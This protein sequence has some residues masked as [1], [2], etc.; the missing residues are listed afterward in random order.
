VRRLGVTRT[1]GHPPGPGVLLRRALLAVLLLL[2]AGLAHPYPAG[3]RRERAPLAGAVPSKAASVPL[4]FY[5]G[6][7]DTSGITQAARTTGTHPALAEDF[8]VGSSGW[9][10]MVGQSENQWLLGAWANKGYQ[11]V[12]GV[13]IIP[14][15]NG[16]AVGTLAQ[17]ATG[18]YDGYF[19]TLAHTLVSYGDANAILRLGWEFNGNWYTWAVDNG[20]EAA[21]YAAYFDHIVTAMRA[22][23]PQFKFVWNTSDATGSAADIDAAY[24]GDAYV[25]YI[26]V[27]AYDEYCGSNP[28]S[29]GE[30]NNLLNGVGGLNWAASF[31]AA[32]GKSVAVPEWGL[33][34]GDNSGCIGLG[35][36]PN[37]VNQMASWL[38]ANHAAF[39]S[40]FDFDASDA[41]HSLEDGTFPNAVAAFHQDFN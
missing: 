1:P 33:A 17:G 19:T 16:S 9:S 35:D 8:L 11:L 23:S 31:A 2:L 34:S 22:V 41:N 40:Y 24:P 10:G 37:Y 4:G 26:G 36:D 6:A 3:P 39:S 18:A 5:T 7:A 20:T 21:D 38:A 27:D 30:W 14:T 25:D 29:Q 32:H 13:P 12:L 15:S 28:S